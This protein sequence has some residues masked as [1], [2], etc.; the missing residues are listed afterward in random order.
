[1]SEAFFTCSACGKVAGEIKLDSGVLVRTS[2]ASVL[3]QEL[4]P[5][6]LERARSA[7]ENHG[8][9]GLFEV[10]PEYA[11]FCCP[12]CDASYCGDH[13]QRRDAFD[14]DLHDEIR[15]RC[16]QGHERMLED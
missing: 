6:S 5:P 4:D 9:R 1:V 14:G 8:A 12:D 11:P 13:W 10:D 15:G 2:F 3:T 16:P 7:L